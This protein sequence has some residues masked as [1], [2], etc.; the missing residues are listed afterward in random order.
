VQALAT[1]VCMLAQIAPHIPQLAGSD[2]VSTQALPHRVVPPAQVV[3][4]VPA[5]Q[6]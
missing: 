1:H 4:Q 2:V 6:P 3:V 5:E